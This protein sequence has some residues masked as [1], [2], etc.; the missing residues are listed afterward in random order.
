MAEKQPIPKKVYVWIEKDE[1]LPHDMVK[2]TLWFQFDGQPREELA[3][4]KYPKSPPT[5]DSRAGRV[6]SYQH[7][8]VMGLKILTELLELG[9]EVIGKSPDEEETKDG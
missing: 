9:I 4:Q 2:L 8:L 7:G 3:S 6:Y 1:L 5:N